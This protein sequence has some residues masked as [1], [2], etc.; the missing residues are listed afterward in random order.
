MRT[1]LLIGLIAVPMIAE[2]FLFPSAGGGRFLSLIYFNMH[3][4]EHFY[5]VL[6]QVAAEGKNQIEVFKSFLAEISS[7][8]QNY[9][10][11]RY[12]A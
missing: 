12:G 6:F 4:P 1:L 7:F 8:C 9:S 10:N 5:R 3:L 2:A 11:I